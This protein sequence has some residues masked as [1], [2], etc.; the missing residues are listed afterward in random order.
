MSK[1]LWIRLLIVGYVLIYARSGRAQ[2]S[3]GFPAVDSLGAGLSLGAPGLGFGGGESMPGAILV[4]ITGE[5]QCVDCTLEA[6][7]LE[8]APGDLY[9]LSH[10]TTHMV[11]KVTRAAPD[12]AWEMAERHKLFLQPG[13]DPAQF[14][15]LLDEGKAGSRVE[16]TGGVAP[17]V[18]VLI[19]LT[20]K[21]K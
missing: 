8:E 10:G 7:G 6:M 16:V 17:E 19:P 20:V 21:V 1:R 12:L 9:Q 5:V 15:R 2:G 4:K 13:E 18:G 14:Q 11:L 3:A